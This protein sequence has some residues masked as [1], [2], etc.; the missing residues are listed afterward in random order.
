MRANRILRISAATLFVALVAGVAAPVAQAR[1]DVL[2]RVE[3]NDPRTGEQ[4]VRL[5]LP[6]DSIDQL[7]AIA[8]KEMGHELDFDMGHG[9]NL[10]ALYL[11]FRDEDL[12]DFLEVNSEDGEHVRVWKDQDAFHVQVQEEGYYEP[13]VRIYMPLQVLD[14]LFLDDEELDLRGALDELRNMAPL[15]LVEVDKED[16]NIRIWLE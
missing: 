16:E 2:L 8:S 3:V 14:V 4:R 1:G 15:T 11:A 5:N 7:L 9:M 12:S 13:N 10:R 6:L